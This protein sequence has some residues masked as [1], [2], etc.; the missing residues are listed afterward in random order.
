[1]LFGFVKNL[2][3]VVCVY[4]LCEGHAVPCMCTEARAQPYAAISS[5]VYVLEV[6]L[7][8]SGLGGKRPYPPSYHV[9]QN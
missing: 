1:M 3:L 6:R 7:R 5:A 4:D 9:G 8:P 2:Y